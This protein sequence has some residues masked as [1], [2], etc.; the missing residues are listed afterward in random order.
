MSKQIFNKDIPR[1]CRHCSH[2]QI[3]DSLKLV[4]CRHKGP[5]SENDVC[6]KFDYDPLKRTPR[7][8]AKLP[9][10]KKEDFEL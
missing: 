2:A 1:C 5:V 4:F 10:Y 7:T 9:E 3:S 6:K 8:A